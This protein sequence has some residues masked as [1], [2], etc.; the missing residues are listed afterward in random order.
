MKKVIITALLIVLLMGCQS[1]AGDKKTSLRISAASSL[2]SVLKEIAVNFE[3]KTDYD[4]IMNFNSSGKL[5]RQIEKGAPGDVYLSA[6]EKWMDYALEKGL[7]TSKSVRTVLDNRLVL[8]VPPEGEKSLDLSDLASSHVTKFAIGDP[9]SVPAGKY[10]KEALKQK[11]LWKEVQSKAVYAK[12]VRQ[13]AAYVESGN[14]DA[15]LVY[16]SDVAALDGLQT[17]ILI[18]EELHS[19]IHY[20]GAVIASSDQKEA[21]REFLTYMKSE[22]VKEIYEQYGFD[23]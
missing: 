19:P 21:A 6:S 1:T 15:G 5:A 7:V 2:T 23:G 8:A 4:L 10:A 3:E 13:V 14:V 20:F 12:N 18:R 17:A 22:Q 11:G 9:A 16:R